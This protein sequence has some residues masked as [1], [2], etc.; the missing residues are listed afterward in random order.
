M[1]VTMTTGKIKNKSKICLVGY[2]DGYPLTL[3]GRSITLVGCVLGTLLVSLMV[4]SLTNTSEL[5][6]G[7]TR[8]YNETIQMVVKSNTQKNATNLLLTIF[9]TFLV[10]EKMKE[11][12]E[13]QQNTILMKK[14]GLLSRLKRHVREFKVSYKQF[15]SYSS[16]AED[17]L[18]K[19]NQNGLKKLK[20]VY[21]NFSKT[22]KIKRRCQRILTDQVKIVESLD[23][24]ITFQNC[25]SNF[26]VN[27][28]LDYQE[29]EY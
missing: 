9:Q 17:T 28:N 16:S 20:L 3:L 12:K 15:E 29:E 10:N 22:K 14:F 27:F 24:I 8:V 2:G 13:S 19:L 25:I 1:M 5:S 11:A 21:K 4:V 18:V 23:Q 6:T 7:E 26:L